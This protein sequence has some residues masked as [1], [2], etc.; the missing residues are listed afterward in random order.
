MVFLLIGSIAKKFDVDVTIKRSVF[1]VEVDG[2][3]VHVHVD[4]EVA[5]VLA[6][7]RRE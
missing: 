1:H 3:W 5:S 7:A 2:L 6:S 4:D